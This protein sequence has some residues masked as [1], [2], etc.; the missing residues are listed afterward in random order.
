MKTC[1]LVTGGF[2]PL[3]SGH[4]R[5]LKDASYLAPTLIV[6]LNSDEWLTRKKGKPFM[7]YSE[8][9]AVVSHLTMVEEVIDFRDGDDT[10]CTAIVDLLPLSDKIIFDQDGEYNNGVYTTE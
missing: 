1:V 5:Y 3:H 6:G 8:R 2:D 7:N 4:I 9:L 10:D